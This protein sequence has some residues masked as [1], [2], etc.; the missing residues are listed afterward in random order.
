MDVQGKLE[1]ITGI[2]TSNQVVSLLNSQEDTRVVAELN[3][4]SKPLG[5]YGLRDWQVLKVKRLEVFF[6]LIRQLITIYKGG[7]YESLSYTHRPVDGCD[8]S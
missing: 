1:L 7:R 8:P 6:F 4:D 5:F 3:D 2:P